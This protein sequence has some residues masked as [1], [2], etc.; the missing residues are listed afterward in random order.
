MEKQLVA[1]LIYVIV[2]STAC[3][4]LLTLSTVT[5]ALCLTAKTVQSRVSLRRHVRR[6]RRPQDSS[7]D[8]SA[9]TQTKTAEGCTGF[10][11]ASDATRTIPE[12]R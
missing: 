4:A 10:G 9:P 3:F 8:V 1:L 11:Q 2:L 6:R 7:T 5:I 12:W